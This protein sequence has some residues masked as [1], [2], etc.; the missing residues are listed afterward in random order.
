MDQE[1]RK[2]QDVEVC[3]DDAVSS[4][5]ALQD[6]GVLCWSAVHERFVGKRLASGRCS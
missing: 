4:R 5:R 6:L 2:V 1:D 3:D